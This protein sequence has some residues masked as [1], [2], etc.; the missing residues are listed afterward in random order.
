[1]PLDG[2]CPDCSGFLKPNARKCACGWSATPLRKLAPVAG[3]DQ[4][5]CEWLSNGERCHWPG[6]CS[7]D[8]HGGGPWYCTAHNDCDDME[9]GLRIVVESRACT[10]TN[11]SS[12]SICAAAK[13]AYL[14]RPIWPPRPQSQKP[15]P[16]QGFRSAG[17]V[18]GMC[19]REPGEEG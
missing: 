10:L 2:Q 6:S 5:R 15:Q 8:T 17:V 11:Y 1:M 4:H 3:L 12:E 16:P 18:A 13:A 19:V 9:K 14:A 7:T